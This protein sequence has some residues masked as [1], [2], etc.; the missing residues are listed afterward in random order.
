M[1]PGAGDNLSA[2]FDAYSRR[3]VQ[4]IALAASGQTDRLSS[5]IS[6]KSEFGLGSGDVGNPLGKGLTGAKSL[7]AELKAQTFQYNGWDGIPGPSD[8][9]GD[10]TV[11]VTFVPKN[12][13]RE[14]SVEFEY[15]KGVLVSAMGWWRSRNAGIVKVDLR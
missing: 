10:I 8:G 5:M 13:E 15:R 7:S 9:C 6:P 1:P 2:N 14:S 4:I 11:K 3:S 12:L